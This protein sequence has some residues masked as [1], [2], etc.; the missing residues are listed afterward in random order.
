LRADVPLD[1]AEDVLHDLLEAAIVAR[2]AA[3]RFTMARA[4]DAIS[5][6]EIRAAVGADRLPSGQDF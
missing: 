2:L 5:D 4:R 1:I 3:E 6:E